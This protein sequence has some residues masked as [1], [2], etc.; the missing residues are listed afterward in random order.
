MPL[1]GTYRKTGAVRIKAGSHVLVR[2][3]AN[4]THEGQVMFQHHGT[5][6]RFMVAWLAETP[7][8][9][10]EFADW[11]SEA[12]VQTVRHRLHGKRR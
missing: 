4:V 12:N 6:N 1:I 10:H 8:G 2:D 7:D 11:V 3:R 5:P 9:Y